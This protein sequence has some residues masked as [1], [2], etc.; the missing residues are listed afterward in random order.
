MLCF[1]IHPE[2]PNISFGMLHHRQSV[3][4]R[5]DGR[6]LTVLLLIFKRGH[7]VALSPIVCTV[8]AKVVPS[9]DIIV[10]I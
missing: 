2:L 10:I 5:E 1:V 6:F 3:L 4:A 9:H 7:S 8:F